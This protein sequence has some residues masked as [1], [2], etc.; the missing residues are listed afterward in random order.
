MGLLDKCVQRTNPLVFVYLQRYQLVKT[1][2]KFYLKGLKFPLYLNQVYIYIG[3]SLPYD[4]STPPYP[5]EVGRGAGRAN[6]PAL[7]TQRRPPLLP[8]FLDEAVCISLLTDA[9]R[10]PSSPVPGPCPA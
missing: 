10:D 4:V 6:R 8:L 1:Q 3:V 7:F 2:L 5:E 9:G